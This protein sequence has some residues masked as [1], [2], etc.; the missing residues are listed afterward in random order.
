M[1]RDEYTRR[2]LVFFSEKLDVDRNGYISWSDYELLALRS[3][4]QQSSWKYDETLHRKYLQHSRQMWENMCRDLEKDKNGEIY[5]ADIV[6]Y[7]FKRTDNV[8]N[9]DELPQF[10]QDLA[11]DVFLMV[12]RKGDG[13]W[14][15][16]EYRVGSVLWCYVTN[17]E[18]VDRAFDA[19]IKDE[20]TQNGISRQRYQE[21][22]TDFF[23]SL[24]SD[25]VGKN[26]F[27]PLDPSRADELLKKAGRD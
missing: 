21:L 15:R 4:F 16:D 12:D 8:K 5:F 9:Y 27:G 10:I 3:T 2:L 24:E 18:E 17:L 20:E 14:D 22:V 1:G 6:D 13:Y 7:M 23:T 26:V 19:M 11:D 25:A